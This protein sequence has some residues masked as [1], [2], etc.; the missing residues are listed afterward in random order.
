MQEVAKGGK[1]DVFPRDVIN[2]YSFSHKLLYRFFLLF[3]PN[4]LKLVF[5]DIKYKFKSKT[6]GKSNEEILKV[7]EEVEAIV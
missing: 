2:Y 1:E 3:K 5:K 7:L 6:S 4:G